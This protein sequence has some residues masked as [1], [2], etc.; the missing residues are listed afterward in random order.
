MIKKM[1]TFGISGE[2]PWND[3]GYGDHTSGYYKTEKAAT[4]AMTDD[5]ELADK[6]EV[7]EVSFKVIKSGKLKKKLEVSN[8]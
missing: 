7:Y 6:G 2:K 1:Y 5:L 3:N 8:V 4:K